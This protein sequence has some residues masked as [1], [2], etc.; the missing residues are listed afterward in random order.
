M[1][2]EAAAPAGL[3]PGQQQ[4]FEGGFQVV[5]RHP[6]QIGLGQAG[7][8]RR[9]AQP[10][11]VL[12]DA[13]AHQADLGHVRAGATVRT[14]RH[15]HQHGALQLQP[16]EQ[17]LQPLQHPGQNPF[18]FG[19]RQAAGGQGRAGDGMASEGGRMIGLIEAEGHELAADAGAL[20]R[21]D[22]AEQ[23]VL[24]GGEADVQLVG[25]HQLAQTGFDL[26]L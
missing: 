19:D 18:R 25:V 11:L 13:A 20:L 1:L 8:A 21:A 4:R 16:L 3:L 6:L 12:V 9:A 24:I 26:A 22:V 17:P 14:T 10:E 23:Q 15:P 2:S 5:D 7:Q